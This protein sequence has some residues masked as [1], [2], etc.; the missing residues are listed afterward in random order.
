M[1]ESLS[2]KLGAVFGRLNQHGTITEKDL[3]DAMREVRLALLEADVNFKVV[4]QFIA[5]VR[6]KALGA[7]IHK[8]LNPVQQ[9]IQ[10]VNDELV[11]VLGKEPSH[12]N[13][14]SQP[15][16]VVMLVGLQG[17][18][19]T[20]TAAKLALHLRS[21]GDKPL[22]VAADVYRPA[23][24]QQ[25]MTLGRQL[26]IPVWEEGTDV[27]PLTIC[28]D[29]LQEARRIG[30]TVVILDTAG[31]LHIDQQMMDEVAGIREKINPQEVLFIADAMQGQEAVRSA[32]EFHKAVGITGMVLTKMDGDARGGA[33]LSIR[34]V[35]GV[36]V[37]F[38]AI[39]EKPD[40]LEAFYPDR[41]ASRILG[42][43]DMLTLIEKA[44]AT[45][46]PNQVEDLKKKMRTGSFDLED[47]VQQMQSVKKM[48][49]IQNLIGMIPGLGGIKKQ[50]QVE[51]DL[52][53]GF[54]KRVESIIYSMTV[55]ERRNP[56]II[57]GSRRRRIAKGSGTTPQDINQL[58]KQFHEAKKI[59][60]VMANPRAGRGGPFAFLR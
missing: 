6:E 59:M 26:Q 57:N 15:P 45:F 48:G 2:E 11:E 25:L 28:Q 44:Q 51:G 23:A 55:E 39:S 58:L 41:M 60:K 31:R 38:V 5:D 36:P 10:I 14:A 16:T 24:V 46:D 53:E 54:F 52:D 27:A 7:E 50:L 32:E 3:D 13:R 8:A 47:F 18:G 40:G 37:K 17:S 20:S 43:G 56:E 1:F 49:S 4:K 33:A 42:M 9:I 35:V 22:M 21:R 34:H 12:L 29:A 30:A 19:K